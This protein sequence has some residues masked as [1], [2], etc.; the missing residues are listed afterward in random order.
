MQ[1]V[2]TLF[3]NALVLSMDEKLTQYSPGAVA[4]FGDSTT[5]DLNALLEEQIG[6]GGVG[7]R[8][9]GALGAD[10]A[11]ELELAALG[12]LLQRLG[13]DRL[14]LL[15]LVL[16]GLADVFVRGH[17]RILAQSSFRV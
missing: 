11:L 1:K 15:K 2:D 5:C 17:I 12:A 10:Q 16:A 3:I 4:V 7:Q 14:E 9:R 8:T 6:K 13:G